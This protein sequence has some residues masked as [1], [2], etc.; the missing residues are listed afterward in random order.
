MAYTAESN[1]Y[2][3]E[4]S[5]PVRLLDPTGMRWQTIGNG[6]MIWIPDYPF[7]RQRNVPPLSE[8][9]QEGSQPPQGPP[10]WSH[11]GGDC[12]TFCIRSGSMTASISAAPGDPQFCQ[13]VAKAQNNTAS[14]FNSFLSSL[15]KCDDIPDCCIYIVIPD[16]H[17]VTDTKVKN[18]A[19]WING[20]EC[21]F[22]LSTIE[23]DFLFNEV[24]RDPRCCDTWLR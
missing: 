18:F 4:R 2:A 17:P 21:H 22:T 10:P 20:I 3:F 13:D 12:P 5:N 8:P 7:P 9:G 15:M 6:G 1:L 16:E 14:R 23:T 11:P 19:K 24:V